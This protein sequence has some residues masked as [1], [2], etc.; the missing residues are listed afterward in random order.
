MAL[1]MLNRLF[2]WYGNFI[3]YVYHLQEVFAQMRQGRIPKQKMG[4]E[5]KIH[6]YKVCQLQGLD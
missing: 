4:S 6:H 5:G 1:L 3:K 2:S